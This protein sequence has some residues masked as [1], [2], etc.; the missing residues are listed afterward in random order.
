M[1]PLLML[2]YDPATPGIMREAPRKKGALLDK[3]SW[4]MSARRGLCAVFSRLWSLSPCFAGTAGEAAAWETG[5][6]ATFATIVTTQFV[7]I[8]FLRAR[9]A[10]PGREFFTN[11][12]LF[13]GIVLSLG[14]MLALIYV[15]FFNM[16]LH[17]NPLALADW[18]IIGLALAVFSVFSAVFSLVRSFLEKE[19]SHQK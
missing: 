9:G 1:L 11:P 5:L 2:T 16:Y 7:G 13:L 17:T 14:A 8:F 19:T 6:A 18:Q 4:C 15:P 10:L 12:Y 3:E